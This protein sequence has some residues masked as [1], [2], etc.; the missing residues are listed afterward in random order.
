MA[1]TDTFLKRPILAIAVNIAFLVGGIQA[2]MSLNVRQYPRSDLAKIIVTT[3][4]TGA[5]ADLVRGFITS[6][7]ERAISSAD[8][9]DYLESSSAQGV[10]TITAQLKLNYPTND[11][12]TQ[13]QAKVSQV[14]NELPRESEA[15][16]ITVESSDTQFASMYLSFFSDELEQNQITDY[17]TRVVQP[18]IL[19]VSGVQKADILGGRTFAMRIWLDSN[20]LK[21]L[22]LSPAAV[23]DALNRNNYLATVGAAKGSLIEVNLSTNTDLRSVEEFTNLVIKENGS[24]LVRL[25]DVAT[26]TLGAENYDEDVRF[27]GQTAVFMGVW[28]LPTANSLDV[29]KAVRDLIPAIARSLPSGMQVQI[30]YDGTNYI[31]SAISEVL[32]T[33]GET[34]LIVIVV[35]FLFLGSL[36][37]VIVPVIA[38]PLSLIGGTMIM[39]LLGFTINLLTLLAIVLS[40]GLVVD[41]AIVMLENV[42]RH[43][44]EGKSPRQAALIGAR[45]LVLPIIAMTIT[46]AAVYAP[47]GLQGG[48]TGTLFREFAFTLAGA[49]L[50]S[51]AVALTLSPVMSAYF[52]KPAAEEGRF[53]RL[54]N[55]L[56]EQLTKRY[57]A[58]L[59][60][61]LANR[62]TVAALATVL[63][64]CAV[65]FFLFSTR[66]LAPREDQRVVFG[67]VQASPNAVIEDTVRYTT[68]MERIFATVPEHATTF[69]LT[70][71]KGG[72]SG[73][74]TKPW[75]E[76]TRTTDELKDALWPQMAAIPGVR[77][78]LTTP[79]PL[80]G[81]S[82]FPVEFVMSSTRE[83]REIVEH[84]NAIVGRAFASGM[85]MFADSDLKF[86]QLE[87]EVVVDRDMV[88]TLNLDLAQ[89]G[90]DLGTLLGGGYV[91]RFSVAGRSYKVIP[92]LLRS[93][94]AFPNQILDSYI[95][96]PSGTLIPLRTIASVKEKVE[97][98][99]LNRFQQLNSAKIQGVVPPGVSIDAGLKVL[100]GA[101]TELLPSDYVIDYAGESRQLRRES[102]ALLKTFVLSLILIFLVLASQ[103]ESIR[104]PFTILFGSVP[105]ALSGALLFTF[106]GFTTLNV[107]SQ[108]GLVTLVG[109]IAKNGVLIV[110]FANAQRAQGLKKLDAIRAAATIRLRPV[111]MTTT[112]TIVGHFPLVLVTGAGAGARNSIGIVLV[113][114]M[115][116]GTFFTLFVVPVIYSFIASEF[117][118]S[119]NQGGAQ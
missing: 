18:Q 58:A 104:D 33:L 77:V 87:S 118:P 100:E 88:A 116:I 44:R 56:L 117:I 119:E 29:V 76:R 8:G 53:A 113:T 103:F 4:Y 105:L 109:L 110:E 93:S 99:K 111:L 42:E 13:V 75:G 55:H 80:P 48:L 98:R 50:M 14:R 69:Q 83:P 82:D 41:D 94:R 43:V 49:V 115:A 2:L 15:P 52:V 1:F 71:P 59:G 64:L 54:V 26:V 62:G 72:F 86:D 78:I 102:S 112:A 92:Q 81:G 114:G 7:L 31:R 21:S 66:E 70:N 79:P 107:Y 37:S 39:Y 38:I 57:D 47:I 108:I 91:N 85:F 19:A 28:V 73:V 95:A 90:Q 106:L 17:L 25:A 74:V 40:V 23:R 9:I 46:L 3:I 20:R 60:V 67:I 5:S 6:P 32:Q 35:I 10:S 22:N 27:G 11:A 89:V 84:A 65:P 97:P 68:A 45:E 24:T 12:L 51:G 63:M 34:I 61:V 101:A 30:P 36:R 96:G 16:I